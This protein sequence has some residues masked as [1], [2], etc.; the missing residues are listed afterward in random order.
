V[1]MLIPLANES[2]MLWPIERSILNFISKASL[3]LVQLSSSYAV[4][5]LSNAQRT[6]V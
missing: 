3:I 2:A 6:E 5:G 4:V 1:S